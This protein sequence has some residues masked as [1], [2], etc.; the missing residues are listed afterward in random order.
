MSLEQLHVQEECIR[1]SMQHML[2]VTPPTCARGKVIDCVSV[3]IHIKITRSR[4][5]G[6]LASVQYNHNVE[7]GKKVM[8]LCFKA[9]DKDHKCY[10]LCFTTPTQ[11]NQLCIA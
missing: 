5:L 2:V 3:V 11:A 10:K 8:S 1:E 4:L 9:L 6:V 7:N